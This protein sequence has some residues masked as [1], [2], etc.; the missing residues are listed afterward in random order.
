M[1]KIYGTDVVE[2]AAKYRGIPYLWGAEVEPGEEVKELDCSEYVQ[3]VMRDL[4]YEDF[5]DGSYNQYGMCSRHNTLIPLTQ[6]AQTPGALVF[7]RS[8]TTKAVC[9]V[10]IV[11]KGGTWEARGNPYNRVG[12]W[13]WRDAWVEAGLIPG[14]EYKDK[15]K[16]KKEAVIVDSLKGWKTQVTAILGAAFVILN[17]F[18]PNLMTPE[19]EQEIIKGI[20]ALLAVFV[21]LKL[22]R[23]GGSK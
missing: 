22:A 7:M 23:N 13:P 1:K 17:S 14:V 21:T 10:G 2:Q 15:P 4:G 11:D 16:E 8:Q 3:L 5:P 9:H 12:K 6:A 19:Q 20:I 18:L